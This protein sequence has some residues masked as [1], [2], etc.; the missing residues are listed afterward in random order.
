M[1]AAEKDRITA[2]GD[3]S[4]VEAYERMSK[5]LEE[6]RTLN[7]EIRAESEKTGKSTEAADLKYLETKEKLMRNINDLASK[8]AAK[9]ADTA[10]A[11][12]AQE[13]KE[14]LE[15]VEQIQKRIYQL[16]NTKTTSAS[17]F[18]QADMQIA[19]LKKL[20]AELQGTIKLTEEER[21][22]LQLMASGQ[23]PSGLGSLSNTFAKIGDRMASLIKMRLFYALTT[24]IR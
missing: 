20:Q 11:K 21:R 5:K 10:A 22:Q 16:Q 8:T 12:S 17:G 7:R 19:A 9:A 15:Q 6:I 1:A 23:I 14:K 2:K 4:R 18:L 3:A 24:Q 13:Q